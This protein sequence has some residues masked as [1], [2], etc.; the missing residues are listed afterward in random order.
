MRGKRP[1]FDFSM[2]RASGAGVSLTPSAWATSIMSGLGGAPFPRVTLTPLTASTC[3]VE[4]ADGAIASSTVGATSGAPGFRG[5]GKTS[6]FASANGSLLR[7]RFRRGS[8][9]DADRG[10]DKRSARHHA[11]GQAHAATGG[12]AARKQ[13]RAVRP[14]RPTLPP[15]P[16]AL[17]VSG[18]RISLARGYTPP[19][20]QAGA[21][22]T[23]ERRGRELFR[24][25][26]TPE[27][28]RRRISDDRRC[29]PTVKHY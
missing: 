11:S 2:R 9:E 29:D 6:T 15:T 1:Y 16:L 25:I 10:R 22:L 3:S 14:V 19:P 24:L 7:G 12:A 18:S 13:N 20:S 21:P 17:K 26:L 28:C 8:E 5:V 23:P 27:T 4:A